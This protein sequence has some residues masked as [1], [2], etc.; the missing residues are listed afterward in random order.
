MPSLKP[1]IWQKARKSQNACTHASEFGRERW[2][3]RRNNAVLDNAA[4]LAC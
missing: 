2:H 3:P 4:V 1:Q